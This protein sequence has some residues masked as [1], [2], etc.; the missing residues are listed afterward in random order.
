FAQGQIDYARTR[1]GAKG[2]EFR[3]ADALALPFPDNSFDAASMAL[4]I[5]FV[6]DPLKAVREMARV[7]RPGGLV[8][9]YMWDFPHHTPLTP[10]GAAMKALGFE[11]PER[12]NAEASARDAMRA[13][14]Q[15]AGLR[16]LETDV[17]R[18]RLH[19]SSFDDFW[20]STPCRSVHPGRRLPP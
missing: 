10:L 6:P 14:W 15:Q 11:P 16:S 8:A 20:Q 13:I 12:P 4:V 18:I 2:A 17:I 3:V 5:V 9:A 1:P 7:V 19:F